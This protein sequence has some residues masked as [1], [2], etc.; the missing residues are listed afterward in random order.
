MVEKMRVETQSGLEF[1]SV[2]DAQEFYNVYATEVGFKI[3]I[4]QLYRSR[5]DGSVNSQKFLCS[6]E[7]FLTNSRTGCPAFVRLQRADSGKWILA[8]IRKEHNHELKDSVENCP[9][10]S[11]PI[12]RSLASGVGRTGIKSKEDDD[13]TGVVDVKSGDGAPTGEPYKGHEFNFVYEVYKF[14]SMCE[15]NT[16]IKVGIGQ[17]FTLNLMS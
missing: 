16:G 17:L 9:Y 5:V 15:A 10:K 14:Y 11:S 7:V 3:Q 1:D 6:K 4:G 8:N 12:A 13:L 2:E